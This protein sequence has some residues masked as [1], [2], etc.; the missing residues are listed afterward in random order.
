MSLFVVALAIAL[1]V[2]WVL[3]VPSR[4]V[5]DFAM[6]VEAA[7]HL[8]EHGS[9][10]SE[11]VYMP[12]YIFLIA[13]V[14]ALGGGWLATKLV[15]AVLGGLGA[16]AVFGIARLI[17]GGSA[18][19]ALVAGLLY[20]LW[21][22]GIAVA[23]VTGTDMPAAVLVAVAA[24]V[25]MRFAAKRPILAAILFGV[26]TGL[27][28]YIRAIVVPL[29]ALSVLV[30]RAHGWPWRSSLR[31][32]AIACVVALV[33]LSPWAVRN[34]LRYG[35]TFLTD[36]HGGLTA[37]VGANPNSDGCYSRSL[38][39]MF[40]DVTGFALLAEPHRQA[41][42]A[43]L[44]IAK[45]WIKFD[46]LFTLG[47]LAGKAERLFVH[48]RAL[49]YWP[50]FRAGVLPEPERAFFVRHQS[51]IESVTDTFWLAAL[52]LALFGCGLAYARR[53]WLALSLLPQAALL[54]ALYTAIFSEPRYRMPICMLLL[55]FSAMA[56]AWL[57]RTG[58]DLV[59]GTSPV[60]WKREA[61]IAGGLAVFVFA[62]APLLAWAGGRL[63]E[64]H[65]W[66]V[67]ECLVAGQTQFCKWR[68]L[69]GAGALDGR[70][71][72][73]GTWN[74][75]GIALPGANFEKAGEIAVETEFAADPGDY[76]L[77]A[78]FDMSSLDPVGGDARGTVLLS[79]N[80]QALSPP[81]ALAEVAARSAAGQ[82]LAWSA[83]CH[84]SGGPLRVGLQA[85]VSPPAPAP[86]GRLWLNDFR[87]GLASPTSGI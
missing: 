81:I 2:A 30:F 48:E 61:K 9:F 24:Y 67:A 36:S 35:E 56:L 3:A 45:D 22:A 12:G 59:Q 21:P 38:N 55:P 25:L 23:S 87:V 65:R 60:S 66:A 51:A 26:L 82:T 86:A 31:S 20:A 77:S 8:V 69:G 33:M 19:I 57:F 54:A 11:Y 27:A 39:R 76:T 49:L 63:R 74:G 73:K 58:R 62:T 71:G 79:C 40:R 10:D 85:R 15:G 18:R 32:A 68:T 83:S 17:S 7:A 28:A 41:D 80:G 53:Q 72:V 44:A 37:L 70:P 1:R 34:R 84:H 4:P 16:G 78:G 47:L 6:Y 29:A 5:G 64:H 46:P 42:R 14:Q 13:P 43:S 75:V 50:L 52:A